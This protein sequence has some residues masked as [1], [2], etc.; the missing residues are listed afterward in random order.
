[1][2]HVVVRCGMSGAHVDSREV[3]VVVHVVQALFRRP[4]ARIARLALD[5]VVKAR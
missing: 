3:A 1:M 5:G 4:A 2:R